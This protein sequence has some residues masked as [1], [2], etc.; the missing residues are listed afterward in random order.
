MHTA[1]MFLERVERITGRKL[2]AEQQILVLTAALLHDVGHGPFSHAFEK[3]TKKSHEIYTLRIIEDPD[4]EVHARLSEVDGGWAQKLPKLLS[5]FFDKGQEDSDGPTS[6]DKQQVPSYLSRIVSS[7]LDADRFDYLIRD[8]HA[9]GTDYG[10]FDLRWLVQHLF[11]N[12][13]KGRFYLSAKARSAAEAYVFARYHM[14]RTVY[15]HKTVRA[16]EVMLRLAFQ[17][18]KELL[19]RA[20]SAE[21]GRP[22]V[23]DAHPA[24]AKAFAGEPTLAQYLLLDD[25]AVTEF[26][27][28][29][30]ESTDPCLGQLGSGLVHRRLFKAVDTADARIED[31]L[32]FSKLA[33]ERVKELRLDP[34]YAFVEDTPADTPYKPYDPEADEPITQIYVENALGK[35]VELSTLSGAVAT[36]TKNYTFVRYYF[37]ESIRD[38]I[39]KVA[40]ST[41]RKGKS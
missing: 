33:G 8:S 1:R 38:E 10:N 23:P 11:L 3:V 40:G 26:L 16:A 18:Y 13:E 5:T 19:E 37:P 17:R 39:D 25:Y 30:G 4:T 32:S 34:A 35:Q 6:A 20:G 31:L 36:L 7:Q 14:Y 24:L 28:C 29:C 21:T 12:E 22:Q 9:T 27:K 2:D 41:L 15:F